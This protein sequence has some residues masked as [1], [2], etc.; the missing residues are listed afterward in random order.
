M[1]KY[2]QILIQTLVL[3]A[4]A[5]VIITVLVNLAIFSLGS[6]NRAFSS[7][8]AFQIAEAGIEYYR[9]HLAHAPQDFTNGTGQPGPYTLDFKD[10]DGAVIG[11][12]VLDIT[13]P[14]GG[15]TIVTIKSTGKLNADPAVKRVIEAKL[16][17]PSLAKYAV[18][19]NDKIRFA[20]STFITGLIHSNDGVRFDGTAYNIVSSSKTQYDDPD[21]SGNEEFGVHTH[22]D[23]PPARGST[24]EAFRPQEAPPNSVPS[25]PDVFLIGRQ[26]PV[27]AVDFAGL[28]ANLAQIKTE[29]QASGR[30]FA[31]S[32]A[33]GYEIVLKINDTFDIYRVTSVSAPPSGCTNA[34]GE[35]GWGTWSILATT[36]IGNYSIPGNGLIFVEDNVW[37]S[38]KIDTARLTIASARFPEDP[39]TNTSI[40]VNNDLLYTN[41]G[42]E[43]VIGLVAQ[44]NLNVGLLSEDDLRIEAALVAKNGRIG[45]YYYRRPTGGGSNYCGDTALRS[46]ISLFGMIATNRRYGFGWACGSIHCSGYDYRDIVYDA[47]LFYSPPPKFPA[48]AGDYETISWQ[49]LK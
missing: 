13:P 21:H 45:R 41:Y 14:S 29:A 28:T 15:S 26:F 2:G 36:A 44:N 12:V 38:G 27:P 34:V 33:F 16:G 17:I 39:T 30:Y 35:T 47:N 5:V 20:S 18:L 43:D 19:A 48:V 49:E 32:G 1:N 24:N 6:I 7:E 42:G 10:K 25:R 46:S 4:I 22:R 11:Q 9:W 3:S 37:V 31:N 23:S 8:Q 40:T